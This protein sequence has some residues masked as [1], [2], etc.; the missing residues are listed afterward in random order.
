MHRK[1]RVRKMTENKGD[2][3]IYMTHEIYRGLV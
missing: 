3:G 2:K 1:L